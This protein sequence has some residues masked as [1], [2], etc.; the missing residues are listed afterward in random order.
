MKPSTLLFAL[1]FCLLQAQATPQEPVSQKQTKDYSNFDEAL[2]EFAKRSVDSYFSPKTNESLQKSFEGQESAR[3][4]EFLNN[5]TATELDQTLSGVT[6]AQ[7]REIAKIESTFLRSFLSAIEKND[8]SFLSQ[9][10][11]TKGFSGDS[12]SRFDKLK[13]SQ[14]DHISFIDFQRTGKE[15][16][17]LGKKEFLKSLKSHM[18]AFTTVEYVDGQVVKVT[19]RAGDRSRTKKVEGQRESFFE[20]L[21]VDIEFEVRGINK[22]KNREQRKY[23]IQLDAANRNGDLQ[24]VSWKINGYQMAMSTKAPAFEKVANNM[25]FDSGKVYT[26]REALRRG[27]YALAVEDFNNDGILD[28]FVGAFGGSQIYL[29]TK[30]G[31]FELQKDHPASVVTLAKSAAFVDLDNDGWKDLLISRFAAD[32]LTGD[33]LVYRNKNGTFAEVKNAFASNILRDYAMPMA[34]ADY[35]GDGLLDVYVGFPGSLDFSIKATAGENNASNVNGLFYNKG[36]FQFTDSSNFIAT[37]GASN[38]FPHGSLASDID[39]D[40]DMD[41]VVM[42]DRMNPSPIY[43]N[44]GDGKFQSSEQT[45]KVSNIGYGMGVSVGD[46]NGDSLPD[47]VMTNATF[48]ALN[49]MKNRSTKGGPDSAILYFENKGDGTFSDK[50][51]SSGL[52]HA[53]GEGAGG[54]NLIDYDNDGLLDLYVVNGLWSGTNKDVKLDSLFAQM[55][56]TNLGSVNHMQTGIGERKSRETQSIFMKMLIQEDIKV[57]NKTEKLSLG[58]FQRNRLFKNLGNGKFLDVGYLEGVDSIADGYMALVADLDKDGRSDLVLR[59]CDPG[60]SESQFPVV[61]VYRNKGTSDKS[62][63]VVLSGTD[64]N[65]MGVGAKLFAT[66]GGKRIYRELQANNSAVQGEVFTSFGLGS[67]AKVDK[68]EII[69]PSMKREEYHNLGPGRY[70]FKEGNAPKVANL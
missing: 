40:G 31:S 50:S 68:L 66:V 15:R 48:S 10:L 37:G 17:T 2:N 14:L 56:Q 8:F 64:S 24:V 1:A 11:T 65:S 4:S 13:K 43:R 22:F 44:T 25:G 3:A 27:G 46:L 6:V 45:Y 39:L 7:E 32:Q 20:N 47:I 62:V 19:E 18:Q 58:G 63:S 38:V 28:A 16:A 70:L 69:W 54:V 51:A 67:A 21:L 36:N 34:I 5:K 41:I 23:S 61:E 35:N 26:R 29:G 53:A 55:T 49:R 9:T 52:A 12:F 60:V 42:D 33:I 57:G 30:T 59:N